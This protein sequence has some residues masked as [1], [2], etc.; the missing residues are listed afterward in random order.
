MHVFDISE[1]FY[2]NFYEG[3]TFPEEDRPT[4]GLTI[5]AEELPDHLRVFA[6]SPKDKRGVNLITI[7]AGKL[8]PVIT[9]RDNR[10][11]MGQVADI[12]RYAHCAN[13]P[14]DH[15]FR[16]VPLRLA[17]D[18]IEFESRIRG[19]PDREVLFVK[20][21]QVQHTDLLRRYDEI[22]EAFWRGAE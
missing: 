10:H 2:P 15:L 18:I 13:I 16:G 9:T 21:V 12:M 11:G 14:L 1:A 22:V 3:Y 4:Y 5:K 6:R 7:P 8:P 20:A 19:E 17:C